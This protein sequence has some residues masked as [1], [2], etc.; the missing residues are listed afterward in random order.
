[1]KVC[2]HKTDDIY[3]IG[4]TNFNGIV[5]F[6]VCAQSPGTILVTCTRP[7][8][9]N[10][11]YLPCQTTCEVIPTSGGGPQAEESGFPKELGF[12]G[13][14]PNPSSGDFTVQYGVPVKGRVRLLLYDAQG[15]VKAKVS[16]EELSPGY[17]RLAFRK[18][19]WSL[20]AGVYFL[21]LTQGCSRVARRVVLAE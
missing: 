7:R 18:R 5:V 6:V 19:T 3:Q 16:D 8:S 9:A 11:Q 2:L 12:T 15:R 13:L 17:Y 14:S 21:A 10:Q 4:W 1:V 20:P